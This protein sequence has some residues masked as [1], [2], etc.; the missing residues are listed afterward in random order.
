MNIGTGFIEI[1]KEGL[2]S[3]HFNLK[4]LARA[5]KVYFE[6]LPSNL[7]DAGAYIKEN[8]VSLFMRHFNS[9]GNSKEA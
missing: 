6:N 5:N 4:D 3:E 7:W 8:K 9:L 2:A 1:L